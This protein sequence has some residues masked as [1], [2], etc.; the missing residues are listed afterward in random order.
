MATKVPNPIDNYV[1]S[2]IR[3][4]RLALGLSEKELG[5]A[6]GLTFQQVQNYEKGTDRVGASRLQ[7]IA[8]V[9][10]VK[11]AFFFEVSM[12][13]A[14]R[15]SAAVHCAGYVT[16]FVALAERLALVKAFVRIEDPNLRRHIVSLVSQINP[17]AD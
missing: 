3:A 1:G 5:D 11:P 13:G 15:S 16:E 12:P 14:D 9:L 4:R 17:S 10:D 8:S 7:K 2:R 6:L